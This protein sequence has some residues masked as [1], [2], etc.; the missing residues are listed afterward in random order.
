MTTS[1]GVLTRDLS[2]KIFER[3]FVVRPLRRTKSRHVVW[4]CHCVCGALVE[5]VGAKLTNGHTRSCGCLQAEITGRINYK[6]GLSH[7]IKEY[8]VWKA[9]RQRVSNPNFEGYANYGGRGIRVCS[10]WD[11]FENF[12]ADMGPCPQG[13]TLERKD[14]NGHYEPSNCVWATRTEQSRNQRRHAGKTWD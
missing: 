5:V 4:E 10:R 11:S 13:L 12:L 8:G 3:L 6:H 7:T 14:V 1:F 2:G 9:M